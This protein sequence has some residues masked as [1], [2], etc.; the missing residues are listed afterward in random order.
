MATIG[1]I[2]VRV[3]ADTA[4]FQ[5]DMDRAS[6][7][8]AK[9]VDDI[10]NKVQKLQDLFVG[11]GGFMAFDRIIEEAANAEEA[12]SQLAAGV[13]STGEAAGFSAQ[14][15]SDMAE[16]FSRVTNY[17]K[18]TVQSAE[19]VLLTFTKIHGD[20][21]PRATK[22]AADLA[23]RMGMDL[24]AA[25][26]L[27]GRALEDPAKGMT[28]LTRAGIVLSS[29]QKELIK[30]FE[31]S[32]QMAKAQ[33][34][35]LT[36]L[37]HSLGGAAEA[38]HN[39]LGGALKDLKESFAD[40]LRD[41]GESQSD[42]IRGALEGLSGA[43]DFV[44]THAKEVSDG[45]LGIA[46]ASAVLAAA[47]MPRIFEQIAG[48]ATAAFAAFAAGGPPAWVAAGIAVAVGA[49]VMFKDTMVD[50]GGQ[51]A[52]LGSIVQ[53]TWEEI[54]SVFEQV[55]A[56]VVPYVQAMAESIGGFFGKNLPDFV[57]LGKELL[58]TWLDA[59]LNDVNLVIS[60]FSGLG[61]FLS[62]FW[63]TH[64]V[65]H[66]FAAA[67]QAFSESMS[68]GFVE[69]VTSGMDAAGKEIMAR[70]AQIT[71]QL[72]E[73]AKQA[74]AAMSS[75]GSFGAIA[76]Q[77]GQAADKAADKIQ[78]YLDKLKDSMTVLQL[79]AQG[80]KDRIPLLQAEQQLEQQTGE[81]VDALTKKYPG[82]IQSLKDLIAQQ[83]KLKAT[84]KVNDEINRLQREIDLEKQ[85]QTLIRQGREDEIPGLQTISKLQSDGINL[86]AAQKEKILDLTA[87]LAA[88]TKQTNDLKTAEENL[89]KQR[90]ATD[91][92]LKQLDEENQKKQEQL[93]LTKSQLEVQQALDK[94][95]RE[96]PNLTDEQA[97][98]IISKVGQG[99]QL[100]QLSRSKSY[101]DNLQA[102]TRQLEQQ[103][104]IGQL[105]AQGDKQ[106][107]DL[108]KMRFDYLKEINKGLSDQDPL[109]RDQ[110]LPDE[111]Q[112]LEYYSQQQSA[113]QQQL[114]DQ[115][116]A[117]DVINGLKD[118]TSEWAG[119]QQ[120]LNDLF[121]KGL[122]T[123]EQY[124]QAW[125]QADPAMQQVKQTADQIAG[126]FTN[127]FDKV[128]QKGGNFKDAMK[129]LAKDV[130]GIFEKN[131]IEKPLQQGISSLLQMPFKY[132]L[133]PRI[134]QGAGQGYGGGFGQPSG[135]P[136]S[137]GGQGGGQ[138][139]F[140]GPLSVP[141]AGR[142]GGAGFQPIGNTNPMNLGGPVTSTGNVTYSGTSYFNG[143][144]DLAGTLKGPMFVD[145]DLMIEKDA[146][147]NGNAEYFGNI[148]YSGPV[149]F[150]GGVNGLCCG[151][152]ASPQSFPSMP[153]GVPPAGYPG[154][155]GGL[156]T[157]GGGFG[158]PLAGEIFNGISYGMPWT[159]FN[160]QDLFGGVG[161]ST[162]G[163][164][165][166]AGSAPTLP[167]LQG[168]ALGGGYPYDLSQFSAGGPGGGSQ[169]Q[170]I[171]VYGMP[172]VFVKDVLGPNSAIPYQTYSF[173][174]YA[175]PPGFGQ[176]MPVFPPMIGSPYLPESPPPAEWQP[177]NS[178]T[179]FS[180]PNSAPPAGSGWNGVTYYG[181][182]SLPATPF[183]QGG[184]VPVSLPWS[185]ADGSD[186]A[187]QINYGTPYG[188][189][190]NQRSGGDYYAGFPG[191]ADGSYPGF[192]SGG[193][194]TPG[195]IALVGEKGPE[196]FV[197]DSAGTV[198]PN[199]AIGGGDVHVSITN[200][201]SSAN[202]SGQVMQ[203][204]QGRQ[205][206]FIIDE[207][208]AGQITAGGKT[209]KAI[210][211]KFAL[212]SGA[213][214]RF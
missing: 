188:G 155:S 8:A 48:S 180:T 137:G 117:Q 37:E 132:L 105:I 49:L 19:A 154:P 174:G 67:T 175:P 63:Q 50:V 28:A 151:S 126:A 87:V 189:W 182:N 111:E 79:E 205:I 68:T 201:V 157:G 23:T 195:Q 100:D 85:K 114:D 78:K 18:E 108:A 72:Q 71:Q 60:A 142:P 148:T 128:I 196:L 21:F 9:S 204:P 86:T 115:K 104:Q 57:S 89:K 116:K 52:T 34:V 24:P 25:A 56:A 138:R 29:G 199:S 46:A 166:W 213:G 70:A 191:P 170:P 65:G 178:Y 36:S 145:G 51:Q 200:N 206:A 198:L 101:L 69:K 210:A 162:P 158:P 45:L 38:A 173:G 133:G 106:G 96:N 98:A 165:S 59:V 203:T 6:R 160:G 208:M 149:N 27:V 95:R 1:E 76:D 177:F 2:V 161:P 32:G 35:I 43:F 15:L 192:A 17:T 119:K 184:S 146:Y 54:Q 53:A 83:E 164:T 121:Q 47:Q 75:G 13:K 4:Q 150:T 97:G 62:T 136:F 140:L 7:I 112:M 113:A 193:R 214:V 22:A 143:P 129:G 73:Q 171:P 207:I 141:A 107:A 124:R 109:Y 92:Y 58:A 80:H 202:V 197:P 94:A 82:L 66:A 167:S 159:D 16:S 14:Q 93:T 40:L 190:M 163:L 64:D 30:S 211:S 55:T 110:L 39:T 120:E 12:M 122:L 181:D 31:G 147:F 99:Q 44:R 118:K 194:P 169:S 127:A 172:G 183:G 186:Y 209:T 187:S 156:P 179:P 42:G 91:K 20:T 130:L 61:A 81:S 33:D 77:D 11:I 90:D 103:A 3:A 102:Q 74:K 41:V 176:G 88:Q 26:K 139:G 5:T 152:G 123:V 212:R 134:P 131:L 144:I 84:I 135:W 125:L 153:A 10:A 185:P 168:A